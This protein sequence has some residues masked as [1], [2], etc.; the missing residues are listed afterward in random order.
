MIEHTHKIRVIQVINNRVA[1]TITKIVGA[2]AMK[3]MGVG[4]STMNILIEMTE[5]GLE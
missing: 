5:W 2:S 1:N 3:T 4:V